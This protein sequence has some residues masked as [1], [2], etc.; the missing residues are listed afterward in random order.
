[1][2]KKKPAQTG[3]PALQ[4]LQNAG[5][6]YQLFEYQHSAVMEHGYAKDTAEILGISEEKVYK[7]LLT[8]VDG[9]PA[10]AVIPASHT[11]NLK[12]LAKAL[13]GKHAQMMDPAKAQRLTGYV[14]G[15][16]SP[17]GQRT[18]LPTVLDQSAKSQ[19]EILISGGKRSL[20]VALN[21][22]NLAELTRAVWAEITD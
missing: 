8:E 5:V 11:L 9:N 2:P 19:T 16:I 4:A 15:G 1:M 12:R 6:E 18:L 13:N 10:V 20:S 7:T 3:T 21:P 14:T 17:L 22:L